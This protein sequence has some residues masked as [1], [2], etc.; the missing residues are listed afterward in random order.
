MA[1]FSLRSELKEKKSF[2]LIPSFT[3]LVF[4]VVL[5][6]AVTHTVP[7]PYMFTSHTQTS[8]DHP[9]SQPTTPCTSTISFAPVIHHIQQLAITIP[10]SMSATPML[11]PANKAPPIAS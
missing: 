1:A 6:F 11:L 7:C 9:C 8:I 2:R 4:A 3:T 5:M 10:V